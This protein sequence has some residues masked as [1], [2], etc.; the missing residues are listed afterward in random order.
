MIADYPWFGCGPGNFKQ[1][2]TAYK[3]PEA[4]E[5]V[6]DPHN[7]LLELWATSGS[8]ALLAFLAV[9]GCFV[10]AIVR[11]GDIRLAAADSDQPELGSVR[12][13]YWG[14]VAGGPLGLGCGLIVQHVPDMAVFLVGFPVAAMIV[15]SWHWW[16]VEGKLEI[17]PLVAALLVLVVNLLVAGGISFAGVSL[18]LWVLLAIVL[19]QLPASAKPRP[20]SKPIAG[21]VALGAACLVGGFWY[22]TY[23]PVL[24]V[25]GSLL[26]ARTQLKLGR[27]PDAEKRFQQAAQ[28]DSYSFEPWQDLARLRQQIWLT[29]PNR[30]GED[31][32]REAI[33]ELLARHPQS[34]GIQ[35]ECGHLF[36]DAFR[37]TG[38]RRYLEEA[39]QHYQAACDRYPNYNLGQA[40]L[41][42]TLHLLGDGRA[43][44]V[45]RQALHLDELN[46]HLERRLSVRNVYDHL[47]VPEGQPPGPGG[48]NAEQLMLMLR[49]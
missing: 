9:L 5:T 14:A 42:W 18:T 21:V 28:A 12:A 34:E 31:A 16:V 43:K 13:V 38:D 39:L 48:A 36:L 24:H 3:L 47:V 11:A 20:C 7:F 22:S 33:R 17:V 23:N 35:R 10:M 15:A 45:A 37:R 8:L 4:S 25:S 30:W 27:V 6:A 29:Q 26:D 32:F 46:P 19:N 44:D 2:Y 49:K 1:Y 41:A 40:Q